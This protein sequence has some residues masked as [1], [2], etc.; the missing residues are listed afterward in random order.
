[1]KN[2]E[3]YISN[4]KR[5]ILHLIIAAACFTACTVIA[6]L[7]FTDANLIKKNKD[8]GGFAYV[9]FF[10]FMM[11]VRYSQVIDYEFNF[12]NMEY[13]KIY[14]YGFIKFSK[15]FNFQKLKYVAVFKNADDSYEINLWHG[16]NKRFMI[17]LY[18]NPKV[19]LRNASYIADKL[20]LDVWDATN[21]HHGVWIDNSDL[22]V[23][24]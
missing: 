8:Y 20:Q 4:G 13:K 17:S 19:A 22:I 23:R 5:P 10:V 15:R 18:D 1:M 6:Y 11:G 21:P 2:K 12:E 24:D 3:V 16:K 14:T 9:F 7:F